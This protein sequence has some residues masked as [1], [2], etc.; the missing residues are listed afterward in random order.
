MKKA[1]SVLLSAACLFLSGCG[2]ATAVES[3]SQENSSV[4][5]HT[6]SFSEEWQ[7]SMGA[8]W[9]YCKCGENAEYGKHYGDS[10]GCT[11]SPVCKVCGH[12]FGV[13]RG[14]TYGTEL[15]DTD[16][17]KGYLCEC[18]EILLLS[19]AID[20]IV[21][22]PQGRDPIVLQMSDPQIMQLTTSL[23]DRCYRYM[24]ETVQATNPDL[25]L[26]TGDLIYGQ[27]DTATGEVFTSFVSFM[28]SLQV[29]WAPVF[30]N[31]DN[32]CP[33][34]VDWQCE[35]LENAEYCLFKQRELTGNGNYN[36]GIVQNNEILRVFYMLDSNGCGKAS[37]AS[38]GKVKTTAGFGGDQ[39]SWYTDSVKNLKMISPET[40]ISFAY[41][42]QQQSFYD[43]FKKYAVETEGNITVRYG[44]NLD[45]AEGA[46]AG[47]FGYLGAAM[48]GPWDT[49]YTVFNDMKAMGVD[50]IFVGH[51]HCNSSSI[52]V[53]GV[54]FQYGQKCSTYDRYNHLTKDGKIEQGNN[55]PLSNVT[56]LMGGSVVVLSQ[57]D[58][59]IENGWI[60]YCGDP[61]GKNEN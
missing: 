51:E 22:V 25:I 8:H 24:R 11:D 33:M 30:G 49:D 56:P 48:K 35:Q 7:T 53:D 5:A 10:K 19:E 59:S 18:G 13:P 28:E 14:H 39:I 47:D 29:P 17:G 55:A 32:E 27:F 54:R 44:I 36:V 61:F 23:E 41:H 60:Y 58:G 43:S 26:L 46:Y 4:T 52:V 50:S 9:R 15:T 16:D 6:H 40:K 2:G 57:D 12:A 3:S 1:I 31:H 21:E 42:I 34:G 45:E 37:A 20:F 38:S